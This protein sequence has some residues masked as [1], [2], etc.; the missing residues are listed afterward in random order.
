MITI[1][2]PVTG[3]AGLDGAL[4]NVPFS[5]TSV[6]TTTLIANGAF[7]QKTFF[8]D[9]TTEGGGAFTHKLVLSRIGPLFQA[10]VNVRLNFVVPTADPTIEIYDN[11][12]DGTLLQSVQGQ[13]D[14]NSPFIFVGYYNGTAWTKFDGRYTV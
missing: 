8:V 9:I 1:T 14:A 2:T 4:N 10:H 12:V 6:G 11:A 13:A 3:A 5:V 7:S